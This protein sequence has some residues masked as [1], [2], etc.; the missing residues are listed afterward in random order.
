MSL[1]G[2]IKD[3]FADEEGY[4][5]PVKKDMIKVEIAA[6]KIEPKEEVSDNQVLAREEK[7][8]PVFF[9]DQDFEDINSLKEVVKPIRSSYIKPKKDEEKKI[10]RPT[11]IISPVYGVLDKNYKKDDITE[12]EKKE[13]YKD[14]KSINIDEIR[15][16]AFG[17]LDEDLEKELFIDSSVD[18]N[19]EKD[20]SPELDH[21]SSSDELFDELTNNDF[22]PQK[23]RSS[24]YNDLKEIETTSLQYEEDDSALSDSD[25]FDSLSEN[26]EDNLGYNNESFELDEEQ[27]AI[28]Y[29]EEEPVNK[30]KINHG[31]NL[32]EDL[33][34]MIDDNE[35]I[36][37]DL[38][39][40]ID[41]MYERE[42][43]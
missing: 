41:S 39:N 27:V 28:N 23:T 26:E 6:P 33:Q 22:F 35:Q 14:S 13:T 12:K 21:S 43:D 37:E 19:D 15:K 18:Y 32:E 10:F 38:F 4:D 36:E 8:S 2:K 1:F 16:K 7:S 30:N 5:E 24:M 42:D 17:T 9:N 29:F 34:S 31:A 11:P 3:L 20:I 25:L 40:L